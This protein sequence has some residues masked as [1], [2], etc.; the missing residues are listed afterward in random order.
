MSAFL[1]FPTL[2]NSNTPHDYL[3]SFL[4]RVEKTSLKKYLRSANIHTGS[5][6]KSKHQLIEM[7]MYGFMCNKINDI[8][9]I[10]VSDKGKFKKNK[11]KM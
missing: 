2:L 7:I 8:P 3:I 1:Y 5:T 6:I 9:S 10:E 11:R 4:N